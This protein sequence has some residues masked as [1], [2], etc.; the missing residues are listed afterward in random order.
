VLAHQI[1]LARTVD[2]AGYFHILSRDKD[3]DAL[4]GHLKDEGVF[5]A[6]RASFCEILV[7]M[8][9]DER[10]RSL[11]AHF[12]KIP[13]CLPRK[14]KKLESLMQAHFGSALSPAEVDDTVRALVASKIIGLSEDGD[15][16]YKMISS[17]PA[18]PPASNPPKAR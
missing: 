14:R 16:T 11:A 2:P 12:E 3:F 7:L 13:N 18:K 1:G 17:G 6:R 4:I 5:A 15:V 8:D 9:A 10:A